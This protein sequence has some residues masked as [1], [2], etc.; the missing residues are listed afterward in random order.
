MSFVPT[1]YDEWKHCITVK[2]D[3]P[4]TP[5]YVDERIAALTDDGDYHTQ[6]FI[7]RWGAKHHAR[8]LDWFKRAKEELATCAS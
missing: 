3:I 5:D 4:L 7:S 6:K 1:T 2:C 8:T